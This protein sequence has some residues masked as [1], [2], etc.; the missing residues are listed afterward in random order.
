MG[1]FLLYYNSLPSYKDKSTSFVSNTR[2]STPSGCRHSHSCVKLENVIERCNSGA[3]AV[4]PANFKTS[5][6]VT[7]L[8]TSKSFL[9]IS[10]A[11]LC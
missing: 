2:K 10:C 6:Y 11:D 8:Q 3:V 1:L 4:Q 7:E 5:E 9:P